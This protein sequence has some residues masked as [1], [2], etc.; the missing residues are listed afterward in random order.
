MT[1][2]SSVPPAPQLE[3]PARRPAPVRSVDPQVLLLGRHARAHP[4]S[5]GG[6]P[7]FNSDRASPSYTL[8][9]TDAFWTL[10]LTPTAR[11]PTK[12]FTPHLTF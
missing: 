2:Q 11:L 10:D 6:L 7:I 8:L 1:T 3:K 5:A 9:G 12:A 4:H